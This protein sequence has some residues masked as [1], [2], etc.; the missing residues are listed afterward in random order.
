MP[1]DPEPH[2][3]AGR[4]FENQ[5]KLDEAAREYQAGSEAW[6]RKSAEPVTGL[7]NVYSKQKKYPEAEAAVAQAVGDGSRQQCCAS[8]TGTRSGG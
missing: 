1:N 8:S 2:L 3:S 5:N 7:A 4:V 6:T